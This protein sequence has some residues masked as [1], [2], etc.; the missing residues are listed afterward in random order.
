MVEHQNL[1]WLTIKDYNGSF[2]QLQIFI[3]TIATIHLNGCISSLK[4][5][6]TLY[7]YKNKENTD[8]INK[9]NYKRKGII[10]N[11]TQFYPF[12]V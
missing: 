2:K 11:Y 1:Q 8:L 4:S 6:K 9:N 7:I 10:H 5:L 3:Q 12:Y